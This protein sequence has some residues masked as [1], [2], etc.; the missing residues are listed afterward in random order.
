[1]VMRIVLWLIWLLDLAVIGYLTAFFVLHF[2]LLIYSF[3]SIRRALRREI[4]RPADRSV[5]GAFLPFV[6]LLVPAYN[7]EVTIVESLRSQLSLR[8]PAYEIVVCNDG[9]KDRTVDVL[10]AAFPFAPVDVEVAS[11]L[12][13]A[14]IR[15]IYECRGPLPPGVARLVLID[16]E[17]GGKADALNAAVNVARGDFVTSMDADTLLVPDALLV[18]AQRILDEPADVAAVGAQVGLSNGS[19]VRGG[20]IVELR[21]PTSFIARCQVVEYMRSFA[22]GRTALTSFNSLLILSG[23]FAMMRRDLVLDAG[24]F[25]TRR[26]QARVGIEYCTRGAHTVCEDMEIIVRLHRYQL[27]RGRPCKV[28]SLPFPLA[29]TEA[30][31]R[32]VDLGKQRAR[33]YRGLLEVLSYHRAA[34][35]RPRLKQLGLFALPYQLV[36]EAIAPPLE[37]LGYA[38]LVVTSLWGGLSRSHLIAFLALAAAGNLCL[39]TLSILLCVHTQR[40]T[41]ADVRGRAL[42]PYPRLRDVAALLVTGLVSNF[43]YRQYLVLWQLRGLKDFLEGKKGWDKFGRKG[44]SVHPPAKE[45]AS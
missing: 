35:F 29:W 39:S 40:A 33:W 18:A 25:L 13:T 1:M 7:E 30:P 12:A 36:F 23:A 28:V 31:E 22:G 16:K 6:T 2:S 9:S 10:L 24:G 17:N 8:Y 14:E 11:T 34:M 20:E 26:M 43:G 38:M 4:V 41:P 21:L 45:A 37:C 19:I 27:D 5:H 44:F 15:G 3:S 32:W 42:V